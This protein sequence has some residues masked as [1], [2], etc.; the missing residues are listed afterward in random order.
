VE[1][2]SPKN[3]VYV[4]NVINSVLDKKPLLPREVVKIGGKG[5]RDNRDI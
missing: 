5:K 3:F 1:A 2:F 4:F